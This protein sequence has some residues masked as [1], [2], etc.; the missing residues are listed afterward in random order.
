[1]SR[2]DELI[3]EHCPDG[4]A[5]KALS[6][7][8]RPVENVKWAEVGEREFTYIDLT[9]VDRLTHKVTGAETITRETAPS[10]AQQLV[11]TGDVIWL[12]TLE[13]VGSAVRGCGVAAG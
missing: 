6:E 3:A 5:F 13:G 2:I 4:V 10:R 8:V 1:M 7:L 9:S 12:F 11:S